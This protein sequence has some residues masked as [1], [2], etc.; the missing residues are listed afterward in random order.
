ML[1]LPQR[2]ELR[3]TPFKQTA[4]RNLPHT[5]LSAPVPA[6]HL[7]TFVLSIFTFSPFSSKPFFHNLNLAISSSSDSDSPILI[8]MLLIIPQLCRRMCSWL[9]IGENILEQLHQFKLCQCHACSL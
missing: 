4:H 8:I 3:P 7:I 2:I 5:L 6:V 9:T 1:H